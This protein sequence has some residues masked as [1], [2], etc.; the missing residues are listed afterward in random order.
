MTNLIH[1]KTS[2]PLCQFYGYYYD[3]L[4]GSVGSIIAFN[5]L[6]SN[7]DPIGY[8]HVEKLA[9]L[10]NIQLRTGCFCNPGACQKF[11]NISA[12]EVDYNYRTGNKVCG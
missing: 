11:L 10:A 12:N 5:L 3:R 9:S 1:V 8:S 7:G 4:Y 2:K 6:D